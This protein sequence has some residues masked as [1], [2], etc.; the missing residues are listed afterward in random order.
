MPN[1]EMDI[2]MSDEKTPETT[3][4]TTPNPDV[5]GQLTTEEQQTLQSMKIQSQEVLVKIGQIEVQKQRLMS[6]LDQMDEGA[7]Q[8]MSQ[9]SSRLEVPEGKNWI[10]LQ[11]GSIRLVDAPGAQSAS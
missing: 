2:A 1:T 9:I 5:I 10:A 6:R 7:S 8:I 4:E 3:E 11:D